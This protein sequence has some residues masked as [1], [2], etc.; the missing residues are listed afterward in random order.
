MVSRQNVVSYGAAMTAKLPVPPKFR[1]KM[2]CQVIG[3][4]TTTEGKAVA[5]STY[6][7]ALYL[8]FDTSLTDWPNPITGAAIATVQ[9][10]AF[11]DYC[12]ATGLY[13]NYRV[14]NSTC[15]LLIEPNNSAD[16]MSVT[17]VPALLASP[18]ADIQDASQA[19]YAKTCLANLGSRNGCKTYVDVASLAGVSKAVVEED[20]SLTYGAVYNGRPTALYVWQVFIT[21]LSGSNLAGTVV[22]KLNLDWDVEFYSPGLTQLPVT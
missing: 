20:A 4:L 6:L 12:S 19:P 7:N 14:Y 1:T 9:P 22:Y 2:S 16:V 5:Y 15:T 17:L 21:N 18:Y 3:T 8:P 10:T 11:T 13:K